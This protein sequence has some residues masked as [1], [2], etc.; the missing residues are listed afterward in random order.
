MRGGT[1]TPAAQ[2]LSA[3]VVVPVL[4]LVLL[5]LQSPP[6]AFATEQAEP[7]PNEALRTGLS[8]AL[9]DCRAYERVSTAQSNDEDT[10]S[11]LIMADGSHVL[12]GTLGF[13][14]PG[15]LSDAASKWMAERTPTGWVSRD[16]TL[17]GEEVEGTGGVINGARS[18]PFAYSEDGSQG[19]YITVHALDP[20][21][22]NDAPDVYEGSPEAGFTWLTED[23]IRGPLYGGESAMEYEGSSPNLSTV[24]FEAHEQLLPEAP[25]SLGTN[26]GFGREIY[27]WHEGHLELA[28]VLPG[29][30]TGA[31]DGAA[32]GSGPQ[33]SANLNAVSADGSEVFFESPDPEYPVASTP[34]QLYVRVDG[35]RTVE[36]SA[37]APGVTDPEGPQAATYVGATPDGTKVFFTSRGILTANAETYYDTAEVLYEYNCKH[38]NFDRHLL[39]PN[40]TRRL[41]GWSRRHL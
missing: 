33:S 18:Y 13:E 34:S 5:A 12:Y 30:D 31:P 22:T 36:V 7:C 28:S 24:V 19:V 15:P 40:R 29:E 10:S 14:E 25:V 38:G 37:P 11:G 8:A 32:V 27:E 41:T 3:T 26:E 23:A 2:R 20:A 35:E 1:L 39:G 21:D 4:L 9:P 17:P 6:S 16:M